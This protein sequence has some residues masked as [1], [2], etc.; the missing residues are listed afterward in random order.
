VKKNSRGE[1][2]K[3]N[4]RHLLLSCSRISLSCGST[5]AVRE[6][7]KN[8]RTGAMREVKKKSCPGAA[9]EVKKNNRGEVKKNSGGGNINSSEHIKKQV[10]RW[11]AVREVK[12]SSCTGAMREVKKSRGGEDLPLHLHY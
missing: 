4:R 9:G 8:S 5:G 6:V 7:K 3:N 12:K 10:P 11:V 1:V 2:K